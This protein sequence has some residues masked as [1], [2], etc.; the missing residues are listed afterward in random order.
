[1]KANADIHSQTWAELQD[2]GWRDE[3]LI[4]WAIEVKI[5]KEEPSEP[6]YPREFTD[7]RLT[8]R[9]PTWDEPRLS[10]CSWHLTSLVLCGAPGNGTTIW[11]W[12]MS[13]HFWTQSL[14]LSFDAEG[15]NFGLCQFDMPDI[16]DFPWGPYPFRG[17]EG[18]GCRK[19][20]VEGA[21]GQ[22]LGETGWYV[23]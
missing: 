13:W 4:I 3:G 11:P 17:M 6:S 5:M 14:C 8:A 9:E 23:K 10:V 19:K 18:D 16:V 22:N 12:C 20:V 21:G 1:M 2:S 7:S 15:K